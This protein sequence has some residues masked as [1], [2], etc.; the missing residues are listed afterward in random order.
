MRREQER[1]LDDNEMRREKGGNQHSLWEEKKRNGPFPFSLRIAPL[2]SC[3]RFSLTN[4]PV[5]YE[6][7]RSWRWGSTACVYMHFC[8][9]THDSSAQ[10]HTQ[11]CCYKHPLK[12]KHTWIIYFIRY[13]LVVFVKW[14]FSQWA[15]AIIFSS[16]LDEEPTKDRI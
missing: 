11:M 8:K 2:P 15:A 4:S 3:L 9:H 13:A 5:I 14:L 16:F 12:H 1:R 7:E 6:Q 10:T